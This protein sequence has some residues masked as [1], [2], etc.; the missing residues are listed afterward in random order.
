MHAPLFFGNAYVFRKKLYKYEAKADAL[1]KDAGRR[2]KFVVWDLSATYQASLSW[3][4]HV[5]LLPEMPGCYVG[6]VGASCRTWDRPAIPPKTGGRHRPAVPP[7]YPE[8]L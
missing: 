3:L 7:R 5:T 8:R 1:A 6:W 2:L 4:S